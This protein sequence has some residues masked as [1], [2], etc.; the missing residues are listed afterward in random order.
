MVVG[1]MSG[2]KRAKNVPSVANNTKIFGSMGGLAPTIGVPAS[3]VAVYNREALLCNCIPPGPNAGW[4][5]M[6]SR[7]IMQFRKTQGGIGRSHWS[8]GIG[9][10]YGGISTGRPF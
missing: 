10:L 9:N 7:G 2:S 6:V 4:N 5:Y 8:P 3:I 1:Y